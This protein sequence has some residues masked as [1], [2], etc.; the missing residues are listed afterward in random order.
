MRFT[1]SNEITRIKD[2][3]AQLLDMIFCTEPNAAQFPA[4][5]A[6]DNWKLLSVSLAV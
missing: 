1:P 2:A 6:K 4:I 5:R 3:F